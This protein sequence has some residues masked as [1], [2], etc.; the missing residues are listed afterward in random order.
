[1]AHFA[2]LDENNTV[3]QIIVVNNDVILENGVESEQKG[4]DFCKSIY[5]S[6]TNWI[7][8]SYNKKFRKKYASIGDTYSIQDDG[9]IP[10][11]TSDIASW[12]FDKN[13]W[14]YMPPIPEPQD[15]PTYDWNEETKSWIKTPIQTNPL[16]K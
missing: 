2:Q 14:D 7:Q 3:T 13:K 6:N 8:T 12:T 5:G 15:G 10:P 9:F 16:Y 1:M 4:I 11:V